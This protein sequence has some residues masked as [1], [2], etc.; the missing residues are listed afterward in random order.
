[1]CVCVCV[2]I[3]HTCTQTHTRTHTNTHKHTHTQ[4]AS[5]EAEEEDNDESDGSGLS[6]VQGFSFFF[7]FFFFQPTTRVSA[8]DY[9][10]TRVFSFLNFSFFLFFLEANYNSDSGLSDAQGFFFGVFPPFFFWEPTT[11]VR[12][13]AYL[14]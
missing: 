4:A 3:I 2:F 13:A 5:T 9:V 8:A 7:L 14:I 11:N 1:V 6:D 12:T 10:S